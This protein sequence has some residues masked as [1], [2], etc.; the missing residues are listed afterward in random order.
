MKQI[1]LALAAIATTTLS[2]AQS[3]ITLF[4]SEVRVGGLSTEVIYYGFEAGD[5]VTMTFED[6]KGKDMK[7]VE[8]FQY[9]SNSLWM[10]YKTPNANKTITI[11]ERGFYGF[12]F[13]NSGT[14]KRYIDVK[15]V[16]K[17]GS[18][19]TQSFNSNIDWRTVTDTTYY[20]VTE[21]YVT[22]ADTTLIE[23]YNTNVRLERFAQNYPYNKVVE[24]TLPENVDAWGYYV[25][26]GNSGNLA[27]DLA[28]YKLAESGDS[29]VDRFFNYNAIFATAFGKPSF[30]QDLQG[31]N[32]VE[33]SVIA[34]ATNA[35]L[36]KTNQAYSQYQTKTGE[37]IAG[38]VTT[39]N[40]G[41]IYIGLVNRHA[42]DAIECVVKL[43]AVQIV[44][45]Y[46]TREVEKFKTNT[47]SK[48]FHAE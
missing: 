33:F 15:I 17:P 6:S 47:Y 18:S 23:L 32:D 22:K 14:S 12:R 9:P 5:Q 19:A 46:A 48:P 40:S 28:N 24:A 45:E 20:M 1:L 41:K 38:K 4:E 44:R 30:L 36:F 7:E 34:D 35:E 37:V 31:N 2:Y 11:S 25:G 16:R 21:Q 8:I 42:T 29:L 39:P 13:K 27:L 43:V 10:E 26:V 3:D